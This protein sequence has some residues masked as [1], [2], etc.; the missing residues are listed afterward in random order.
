[1][2]SRSPYLKNGEIIIRARGW[3]YYLIEFST[4]GEI[5]DRFK[6]EAEPR[7]LPGLVTI[8][9]RF[10]MIKILTSTV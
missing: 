8:Y 4:N 1:M 10:I 7:I 3:N 2:N 6:F 5:V 9:T